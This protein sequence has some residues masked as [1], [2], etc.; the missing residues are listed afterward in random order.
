MDTVTTKPIG[1]P[2]FTVAASAVLAMVICA[3]R[4]VIVAMAVP[5]PSLA[6]LA[7]AVLLYTVHSVADV[8]AVTCTLK[9]APAARSVDA[10]LNVC[11]AAGLTEHRPGTDCPA[12]AQVTPDPEPAGYRSLT[13]TP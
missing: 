10:Q 4:Q 11:G 5:P 9:L 7:V 6:E 12:T 8:A 13:V 1:S 2:A 3:G